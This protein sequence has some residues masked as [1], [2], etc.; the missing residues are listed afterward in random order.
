MIIDIG[1][2]FKRTDSVKRCSY[3]QCNFQLQSLLNFI[4]FKY[5]LCKDNIL[6]IKLYLI[7][8]IY[9]CFLRAVAKDTKVEVFFKQSV[10][11][12]VSHP[13]RFLKI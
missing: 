11:Y 4:C 7:V 9:F 3:Y 10:H 6:N 1:I 12:K 5:H 8:K 2:K 13:I